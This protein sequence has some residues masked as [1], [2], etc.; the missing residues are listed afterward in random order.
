MPALP[1]LLIIG[2]GHMGK[3]MLKGWL[4]KGLSPSYIVNHS[5]FEL[6]SPHVLVKS[7]QEVPRNFHP[8]AIILAVRPHQ[9]EALIPLLKPWYENAV[10]LSVL[11]GKN[12]AWLNRQFGPGHGIVRVMPNTPSE[13]GLG[14]T[15]MVA[16]PQ[17]T[18]HQKQITE[19]LCTAIG[20]IA[21]LDSEQ[22]MDMACAIAGCGPA[23]IFL[24]AELLQKIGEE[25]GLPSDLARLLAR[26]TVIGSA[27]LLNHSTEE[28][29]TLRKA[30]AT[31][32]GITE[33]AINILNHP[34]AWPDS[35]SR[36]LQAAADRSR[37]LSS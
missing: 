34:D 11:G 36:A 5:E 31:P 8:N 12:L 35:L 2:C 7:I 1:S 23:Y 32:N 27:A 9:A 6:P 14:M 29:E 17:V 25:K 18:D 28:S 15:V 37:A 21:W 22:E 26:Q 13:L 33:Q 4:K 30:V 24:L 10:T 3:A 16:N 19:T 20:K